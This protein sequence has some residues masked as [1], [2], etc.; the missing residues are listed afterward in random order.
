MQ[1]DQK[2][3]QVISVTVPP[4][5]SEAVE[6]AFNEL[7]P[8]C[9][10]EINNLRKDQSEDVTVTAYFDNAPDDEALNASLEEGLRIYGFSK[11]VIRNVEG[12]VLE[13]ADWLHNWKTHWKP[14]EAGRFIIA[15][16]WEKV[17]NTDKFVIEI[18]PAMAFGT[19]THDTTRLCLE[20]I[21]E[22]YNPE[23]T[24]LDVG[25]GTGILAIAAAKMGAT[26]MFAFDT[27]DGSI[28]NAR[29][30]AKMNGVAGEIEFFVGPISTETPV[31]DF[32]CA[33]LTLDVILPIL[34]QLLEKSRETL[35]LSG[36]L[37]VQEGEI[38]SA[39][40][41][42]N[43]GHAKVFHSGE[44]ISVVI[45]RMQKRERG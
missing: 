6:F 35:V 36:I 9:G 1:A 16:P 18:E 30:N 37:D 21:G 39:L 20:A 3:W 15:P 33:N 40:S 8:N 28:E 10:T 2:Q 11:N 38:I 32:V 23:Q 17:E 26:G 25:T 42:G 24:F 43:A 22:H 4:D 31:F 5:A 44:W 12:G 29:L 7:D 34:P 27:D 41:N 14:T 13:N 45:E 19:G